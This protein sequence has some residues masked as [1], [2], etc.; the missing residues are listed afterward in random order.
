[1]KDHFI[2]LIKYNDWA[3]K[4]AAGSILSTKVKVGRVE[5]LLA[6]IVSSQKVWLNRILRNDTAGDPRQFF[7]VAECV[8]WSSKITED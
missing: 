7:S 8:E 3:T 6:H 4:E 1:M 5:R 2:H